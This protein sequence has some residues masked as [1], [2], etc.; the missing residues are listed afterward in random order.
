MNYNLLQD[1]F[2]K[3]LDE[4]EILTTDS[5]ILI[6]FI[7]NRSSFQCP[8]CGMDSY[9]ITTYF[10]RKIQD[11]PILNKSLYLEIRLKKFRCINSECSTKVFSETINELALP[12]QRRTNRLTQRLISFSLSYSAEEAS[13]ILKKDHCIDISADTL[14]RLAKSIDFSIDYHAVEGIGVDDFALK[15]SIAMGLSLLT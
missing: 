13:K 7:S 14:L 10:T 11:L 6:K 4:Q 2:P 15:K 8:C 3:Y 9:D 1:Y 5:Q 12:K